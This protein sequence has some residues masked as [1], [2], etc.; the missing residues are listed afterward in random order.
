MPSFTAENQQFFGFL[1]LSHESLPLHSLLCSMMLLVRPLAEEGHSAF[2]K[3][4][5]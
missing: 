4:K 1:A 5:T 3:T 2:Q